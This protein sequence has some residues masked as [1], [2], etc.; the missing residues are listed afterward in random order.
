MVK[1]HVHHRDAWL[2]EMRARWDGSRV[3]FEHA[4]H[5]YTVRRLRFEAKPTKEERAH[6][7]KPRTVQGTLRFD[8][9]GWCKLVEDD[10]Y[11]WEIDEDML[12]SFEPP[13]P[14]EITMWDVVG[15]E[16]SRGRR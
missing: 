5:D 15:F 1:N 13:I 16:K 6:S 7:E 12:G 8:T 10:G 2:A 9:S 3:Q 11:E 4:G 14:G